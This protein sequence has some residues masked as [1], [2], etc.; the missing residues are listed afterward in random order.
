MHITGSCFCGLI[1]Y[2]AELDSTGIGLC[3]CRDCQIF[4]GSAYRTSGIVA[5]QNFRFT[6][7]SPKYFDK[8]ADSG[9]IRRMA[10][11]AECGTHLCS[12]PAEDNGDFVSIR[13]ATSSEF[14][15]LKP[16][17]E[18]FCA[19]RVSWLPALDGALQ[20]NGMIERK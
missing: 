13:V 15:Q 7:G 6:G 16:V 10:F 8:V 3:H 9:A 1:S 12:L 20:F 5:P 17:A 11:C 2:E 19:S 4:S 18:I 14:T